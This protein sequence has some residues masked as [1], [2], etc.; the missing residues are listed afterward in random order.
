MKKILI[1]FMSVLVLGAC[2]PLT[3]LNEDIK[4]PTAVPAGT[5]FANSTLGLMDF[6]TETNVNRNNFRLWSEQWSQ[7][8][9]PDES[10][11]QLV[12]RNVNGYAW[13]TLY[14]TVIR[15]IREA[16]TFLEADQFLE[17]NAKQAQGAIMEIVEIFAFHLLV[18]IFGDVPYTEALDTENLLPSYD[19][20]AAIYTD[21]INRLDAAIEGLNAPSELGAYDLI[22]GGDS[23][24]WKKFANS[25]KLR[26]AIRIA[27]MDNAKA[28]SM[29]EAAIAS[30]VFTSSADDFAMAYEGAT[31]NTNPLWEQ[32]VESGRTDFVASNT[33]VDVMNTLEDPRRSVYFKGNITDMSGNVI[34]VGGEFGN[35]N[36][37]P[38]NSQPGVIFEDPTLPGAIMSFTEVS[39]LLAD[40]AARG[41]NVGGTA[42]SF[43]NEGVSSS[44]AEWGVSDASAYLANPAVAY[45]TATGSWK[46]KIA[47]Q[48]WLALYNRGFEAWSTYRVYNAPTMNVAVSAG[49]LPPHRFTYP[50]TEFSLNGES[51]QAAAAAIGGDNFNS[52]IFWDMN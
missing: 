35:A 43:Y 33:L 48:K 51:V 16:K 49:I 20:D 34:Y 19:D 9:Y 11:F 10:N 5:L 13:N 27:D 15:D 21:L 31:P 18:D 40:A 7:T 6:M 37:Y 17:A 8:T 4:N 41:Y 45:S 52:R 46:E 24:A 38:D 44:F 2:D 29:V 36:S 22:Y 50:V 28:K 30:G 42:E 1:A 14:A 3:D 39:F 32:F 23:D 12:E 26:M 25:L 47:M